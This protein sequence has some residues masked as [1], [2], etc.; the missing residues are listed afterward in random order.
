M[1]LDPIYVTASGS[2]MNPLLAG[3]VGGGMGLVGSL[4]QREDER[5]AASRQMA[6]QERMSNTAHQRAVADM[7]AAGLNPILAAGSAA[8]T[9]SG[10]SGT[11]PNV[12]AGVQGA[13]SSAIDLKR[14]NQE[15][16]E[17]RSRTRL[18]EEQ[19]R[20]QKTL[21][22]LQEAQTSSAKAA[23]QDIEFRNINTERVRD[24]EKRYP[25]AWGA[26]DAI[27]RRILPW[28]R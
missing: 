9:P 5:K 23:S 27:S 12:A 26:F 6:F 16:N 11:F 28:A 2:S 15:I 14:T 18:N 3:L 10:A 19:I 1:E 24:F 22:K 20:S 7:R 17:S 25:G 8:S 21:Q 4:I 13:I